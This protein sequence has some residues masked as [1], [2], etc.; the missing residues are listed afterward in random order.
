[1][2]FQDFINTKVSE[3]V[4]IEATLARVLAEIQAAKNAAPAVEA[5]VNEILGLV[6]I[7]Q[8]SPKSVLNAAKQ[9]IQESCGDVSLLV[10]QNQ[11]VSTLSIPHFVS[12]VSPVLA[13]ILG[14]TETE[15]NTGLTVEDTTTTS[16][17]DILFIS[18]P[19]DSDGASE[20]TNK[21]K[22]RT[23]AGFNRKV[24]EWTQKIS[25]GCCEAVI[26]QIN[27]EYIYWTN[28]TKYTSENIEAALL[29]LQ[30][31]NL[32]ARE[33]FNELSESEYTDSEVIDCEEDISY[34]ELSESEYTAL[35]EVIDCEEDIS[36]IEEE[37]TEEETTEVY[38]GY[39]PED[40]ELDIENTDLTQTS[41]NACLEDN[42]SWQRS[43]LT[44][45]ETL[46][47]LTDWDR[48][49]T[50]AIK[51]DANSVTP[52]T[53]EALNTTR[54]R[55]ESDLQE[56]LSSDWYNRAE[57]AFDLA[58]IQTI[59][60]EIR[61]SG[62]NP[63]MLLIKTLENAKARIETKEEAKKEENIARESISN[64]WSAPLDKVTTNPTSEKK[65]GNRK[66]NV[67]QIVESEITDATSNDDTH[68][69]VTIGKINTSGVFDFATLDG[70]IEQHRR[71][72]E[73]Y[74]LSPGTKL[75]ELK[76]K[77]TW[78]VVT[79]ESIEGKRGIIIDY[80]KLPLRSTCKPI[81]ANKTAD[82]TQSFAIISDSQEAKFIA[83][84]RNSLEQANSGNVFS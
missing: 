15:S 68:D 31:A 73:K 66:A 4:A 44:N 65:F 59:Y 52:E 48:F 43:I 13:D 51:N 3:K 56:A 22:R 58:E 9:A 6:A 12:E 57:F 62:I 40:E 18:L 84:Y 34:A 60:N 42:A 35:V 45:C 5:V 24:E 30:K 20:E 41:E 21:T 55:L 69:Y 63:S 82:M 47:S 79:W 83:D 7:L 70:Q 77:F 29:E 16:A 36:Y 49:I 33:Q 67:K 54:A 71:F 27:E 25:S 37:D 11:E 64:S 80:S 39:I 26:T 50:N 81:N 10:P 76:T 1:M 72:D 75:Y 61:D 8:T 74:I 38:S 19:L 46:E 17:N 23:Q 2:A 78:E 53:I 32:A 28:G 14:E